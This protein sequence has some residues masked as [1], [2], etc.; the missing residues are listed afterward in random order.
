MKKLLIMLAAAA[1]LA[2]FSADSVEPVIPELKDPNPY[3]NYNKAMASDKNAPMAVE[4]QKDMGEALDRETSPK[5]LAK[6]VESDADMSALLAKVAPN[7]ATD[8]MAATQIAAISQLAMSPNCQKAPAL[9]ARWTAA[10]LNAAAKAD[11]DYVKMYFLDQLRWC[12]RPEDAATVKSI[13]DKSS[14]PVADFAALVARELK[15]N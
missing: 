10:L 11:D 3:S 15:S 8:P 13:G 5:T 4:W 6:L 1:S 2:G 7:Y 14:K 12:G 9:R